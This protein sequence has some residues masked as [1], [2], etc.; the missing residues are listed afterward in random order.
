MMDLAWI[1]VG[2]LLVAILVSCTS[3]IN[4]GFLAL[5]MAWLVG[6]YL[7]G[8]TVGE[9]LSGFP[10][11]LFLTLVGVTLLF[12]EARANGT[13]DLV[14]QR[15]V[16]ACRGNVGLIPV[17]F[18]FIAVGLASI[19]AGN[20]AAAALIAPMA[21]ATAGR[22]GISAFLMTIMVGNGANAGGLSPFA[23]TGIIVNG[24]MDRIGLEG[25]E[26]QTYL[27]C[28][29]AHTFVGF[30]GYLIFGGWRL[31]SKHSR[32]T[33]SDVPSVSSGPDSGAEPIQESSF[34]LK[35]G[36]T[37]SVIGGLIFGVLFF[38]VHVG[39]GAFAGAVLLTLL[40][41]ADEVSAVKM[42]PWGP[43]LMVSGVT[44]LIGLLE[45]TGGLALFTDFLARFSSQGSVTAVVAFVTGL[46]SAYSSTSGVVLPAFLPTVPG[47]VERLG[48]GDPWAVASAMNVG[49]HLVD[50]SP[51]STIGAL[52]VA[53]APSWEDHRL[54]FNK[55]LAWGLSMSVVGAA[56]C[57][58][59]FG[60]LG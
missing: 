16:K 42:M 45:K 18:F 6:V 44:V 27:N 20:I 57:Y 37:L 31:F 38:D 53:A 21:M 25:M 29:I 7:G 49:A 47:L 33:D 4:V 11:Q 22:V 10:A 34:E 39:M 23:P 36:V 1:S 9:I 48:G 54:L 55:V 13:L 28:F 51:I 12:S 26:L 40:R 41:M 52:C 15:A 14:A 5:V 24:L 3:R 35:H 2:A 19:G 58:V 17:V 60:L 46:I 56:F 43:I 8:L 50:V 32:Q 59:R 30:S